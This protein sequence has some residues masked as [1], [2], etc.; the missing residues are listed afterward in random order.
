MTIKNCPGNAAFVTTDTL[1]KNKD[2]GNLMFALY[3]NRKMIGFIE[4]E[5]KN[6]LNY[7][8]GKLT[9][10]FESRHLGYG[11]ALLNFAKNKA[12]ELGGEKL[13]VRVIE[14]NDILKDWY[15]SNGFIH[16]DTKKFE[17][18]PFSVEFMESNL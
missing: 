17:A 11:K 18:D 10:L 13:L 15:A 3:D 5:K 16:T 6:E 8:L 12:K 4:L 14:N 2:K 7:E 9:V 1:M